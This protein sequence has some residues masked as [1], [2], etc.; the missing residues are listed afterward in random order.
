M[1]L[2]HVFFFLLRELSGASEDHEENPDKALFRFLID[3]RASRGS[4]WGPCLCFVVVV[5]GVVFR[6]VFLMRF[7]VGFGLDVGSFLR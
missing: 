3:F 2:E 1:I 6:Y 5:C 7:L 4:F